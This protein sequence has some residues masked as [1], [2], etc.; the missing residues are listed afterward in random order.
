MKRESSFIHFSFEV[1]QRGRPGASA[2]VSTVSIHHA[3]SS[4]SRSQQI[5]APG[6]ARNTNSVVKTLL[7]RH[8][9]SKWR[10]SRDTGQRED[11]FLREDETQGHRDTS[12]M[13]VNTEDTLLAWLLFQERALKEPLLRKRE[14]AVEY[15]HCGRH[16]FDTRVQL[17]SQVE[18]SE[19]NEQPC[20]AT[21]ACTRINDRGVKAPR[22]G[23]PGCLLPGHR[24]PGLRRA[25]TASPGDPRPSS[26]PGR[27]GQRRGQSV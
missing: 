16:R 10:K 4:L 2:L 15:L 25:R 13:S 17:P 3:S 20:T 11:V 21:P 19:E 8:S 7:P 6:R 5:K 24:D 27:E 23:R 22:T 26:R 14:G 1:R 18:G 12:N 9:D